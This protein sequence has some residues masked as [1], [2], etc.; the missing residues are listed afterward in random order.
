MK[1]VD[2]TKLISGIVAVVVG[3]LIAV[4]GIGNVMNTYLAILAI[5]SGSV[6]LIYGFYFLYTKKMLPLPPLVLG[7][8]LIAIGVGV[9]TNYISFEVLIWILVFSLFGVGGALVV[10]GVYLAVKRNPALGI[11]FIVIGGA[12]IAL[13]ACYLPFEEFRKVFWIITGILIAVSGALDIVYAFV[14]K[15]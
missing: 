13:A 14:Q 4:L 7:G 9:F 1:N 6:L 3:I 15:K 10:F 12:L 2:L 8:A 11:G 5:V